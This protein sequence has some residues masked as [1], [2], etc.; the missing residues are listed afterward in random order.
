MRITVFIEDIGITVEDDEL[1]D[2]T[3]AAQIMRIVG[4]GVLHVYEAWQNTVN[5]ESE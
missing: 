5:L 4:A 1:Y 3:R 2:D